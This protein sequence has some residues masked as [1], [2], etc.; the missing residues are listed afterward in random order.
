MLLEHHLVRGRGWVEFKIY[1]L[2]S[3]Q[4]LIAEGTGNSGIEVVFPGGLYL[5]GRIDAAA[6]ARR[7]QDLA[8]HSPER[9]ASQVRF[10]DRYRSYVINYNLGQ[11]LVRAHVERKAGTAAHPDRRWEEFEKL[12][13]TPV[14][15]SE[16]LPP[17][18]SRTAP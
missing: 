2:F 13:R 17:Q 14:L 16:L 6:A 18:D 9:A 3:P 8:L 15:P 1:P 7:L 11:D 10:I 5:D 12:L 4:S